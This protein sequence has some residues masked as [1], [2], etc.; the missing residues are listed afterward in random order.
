MTVSGS[1]KNNCDFIRVCVT[2]ET[3]VNVV[4]LVTIAA[5][6]NEQKVCGLNCW[7]L[8]RIECASEHKAF[9]KPHD[10]FTEPNER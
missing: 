9:L 7:L 5:S 2:C 8:F 3:G 10:I 1:G 4:S 6:V